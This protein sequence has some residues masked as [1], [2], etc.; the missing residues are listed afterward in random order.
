MRPFF[1]AAAAGLSRGGAVSLGDDEQLSRGW[2]EGR[3]AAGVKLGRAFFLQLSGYTIY[4]LRELFTQEMSLFYGDM[5][6]V[7]VTIDC[8]SV[9]SL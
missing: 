2:M 4:L 6:V 8:D 1:A 9:R 5:E 3:G 7:C